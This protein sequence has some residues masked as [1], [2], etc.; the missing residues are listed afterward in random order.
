[1]TRDGDVV[2]LL[3]PHYEADAALLRRGVLPLE[4]L[5]AVIEKVKYDVAHAGFDLR[6][7]VRSPVKGAGGNVELLAWLKPAGT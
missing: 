1:V 2:T 6:E 5:D 3:K 7:T 4:N